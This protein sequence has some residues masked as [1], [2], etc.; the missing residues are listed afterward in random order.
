MQ[1]ELNLIRTIF[2]ENMDIH[3]V[4]YFQGLAD[5]LVHPLKK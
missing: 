5:E 2:K 1:V 3:Y 4:L